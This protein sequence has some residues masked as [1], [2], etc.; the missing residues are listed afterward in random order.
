MRKGSKGKFEALPT[1]VELGGLDT[2]SSS[3]G[4]FKDTGSPQEEDLDSEYGRLLLAN[5]SGTPTTSS[6]ETSMINKGE[7]G[8][9]RRLIDDSSMLRWREPRTILAALCLLLLAVVAIESLVATVLRRKEDK[10][11][12]NKYHGYEWQQGLLQDYVGRPREVRSKYGVV[13]S[14]QGDCSEVGAE[15][16]RAGG[17]AADAAVATA[18]CLGVKNPFASGIGGGAFIL[19][20][21]KAGIAN[22]ID[23]REPA[24]LAANETMFVDDPKK[25]L[26]GGLAVGVPLELLGLHKLWV[27][28]GRLNWEDLVLPSVELAKEGF[29]AHPYLVSSVKDHKEAMA[30]NPDLGAIFMP[31][32]RAP[33]VG[34]FCCARPQ[35][36]ET[37]LRVAKEGPSALYSGELARGLAQDVRDAGGILTE[38]DLRGARVRML[39]PIHA[40]VFGHRVYTLPPP[41]SGAVVVSILK[42]LAERRV[43]AASS[44]LLGRHRLVEAMKNAFAVRMNLGDPGTGRDDPNSRLRPFLDVSKINKV[45]EDL[46]SADFA[47]ELVA[48]TL[49]NS[50]KSVSEYGGEYNLNY[51]PADNGTSHLSIIDADENAVSMTMTINTGFGSKLISKR[52]GL[53]LNNEM[54]DFSIPGVPNVYGLEPSEANYVRPGKKP[55]SSMSPMIVTEP[56]RWGMGPVNEALVGPGKVKMVIG[57]SGGPRIITAI[58]QVFLNYFDVRSG[59][60]DSVSYARMHHQLL[61]DEVLLENK[62]IHEG[63]IIIRKRIGDQ[64]KRYNHTVKHVQRSLGV[65]QLAVMEDGEAVGVSDSRKDGAPAGV[66]DGGKRITGKPKQAPG[67]FS[68]P[69]QE[70]KHAG[71][72][73]RE[74]KE[75][76]EH[77][78]AQ[79][80][81]SDRD[82]N[83]VP[84]CIGKGFGRRRRDSM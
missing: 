61:P 30:A 34:E 3:G 52:T 71:E 5:N 66:I 20:H 82:S 75:H 46:L 17:H 44:G 83:G 39:H 18:L 19:V 24:P 43:P 37:L 21:T 74:T 29:K 47:A 55:L 8:W 25:A 6:A 13:A 27:K 76:H 62:T 31:K 36:A 7:G 16:L 38:D 49:D 67:G 22:A 9:F 58:A 63:R 56:P 4:A 12:H 77:H 26:T 32:G 41:S 57:G 35:L 60:R 84:R 10:V 65:V 45:V 40:D 42:Q 48:Q 78:G 81:D 15:A 53:L 79:C 11:I 69:L 23:A 68:P 28:Y 80:G 33:E 1:E 54:D 64:L 14:D 72:G 50:T 70:D 2:M 73:G 51:V 59:A